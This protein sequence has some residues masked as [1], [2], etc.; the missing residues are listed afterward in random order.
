MGRRGIRLSAGMRGASVVASGP[1]K[2]LYVVL[3]LS[4]RWPSED[5]TD[6]DLPEGRSTKSQK[7][8]IGWT[9]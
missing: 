5:T 4:G 3:L 1:M 8:K 7:L 2:L 9:G 6:A